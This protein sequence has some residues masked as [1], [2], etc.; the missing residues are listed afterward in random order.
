MF[1]FSFTVSIEYK[2]DSLPTLQGD[3]FQFDIVIE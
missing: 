3:E 1:R 2:S